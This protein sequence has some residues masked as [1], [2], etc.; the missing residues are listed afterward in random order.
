[1]TDETL[2]NSHRLATTN[3]GSDIGTIVSEKP[4]PQSFHW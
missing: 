4:R 1:M 3:I 2:D